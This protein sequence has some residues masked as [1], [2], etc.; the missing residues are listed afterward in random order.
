MAWRHQRPRR[1]RP[2]FRPD[3]G[4]CVYG[5]SEGIGPG[6]RRRQGTIGKQHG[7]RVIALWQRDRRLVKGPGEIAASDIG[8]WIAGN[9]LA[10]PDIQGGRGRRVAIGVAIR[11][12]K[13]EW[14][15]SRAEG[16]RDGG[17]EQ[18]DRRDRRLLLPVKGIHPRPIIEAELGVMQ[19]GRAVSRYR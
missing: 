5:G 18:Q 6:R 11:G 17:A 4:S 10:S 3:I 19:R 14:R 15:C 13:R 1:H 2:G 12:A 9:P 7:E 8:Q 16:R